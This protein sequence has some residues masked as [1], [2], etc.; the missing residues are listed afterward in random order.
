MQ[1]MYDSSGCGI[2]FRMFSAVSLAWWHSYK[3]TTKQIVRV[4]QTDWIVPFYHH[5]FPDREFHLDKIQ[6]TSLVTYCTYIRLAYPGFKAE[7]QQALLKEH[8][9]LRQRALLTNLSDLCE[10]FLPVVLF[11]A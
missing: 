3:W 6:H 8:L 2:Q 11:Y 7:L 10:C 4:F 5:L 1:L 9:T